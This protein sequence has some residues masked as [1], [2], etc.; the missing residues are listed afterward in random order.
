MRRLTRKFNMCTSNTM[1]Y[2][3][4]DEGEDAMVMMVMMRMMA[5]LT[6]TTRKTSAPGRATQANFVVNHV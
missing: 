2:D 4:G 5:A 3:N 6:T 1:A